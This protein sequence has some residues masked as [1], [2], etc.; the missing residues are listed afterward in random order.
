MRFREFS[1]PI[2]LEY[3]VSM[4]DKELRDEIVS[5]LKTE[6]DR[7]ML[8][9][10]YTA[11]NESGLV[12]RIV[13]ILGKDE[14]AKSKLQIFAG[15]ILQTPGTYAEKDGFLKQFPKGFIDT[16]A[17]T[18]SNAYKSYADWFTGDAFATRVFEQLY[19]FTPQGI[20]PGEYALAIMSPKIQFAG[21]SSTIHGDLVI[22]GVATEVKAKNVAGGRFFDGRKARMDQAAVR[23][24]FLEYD[25]IYNKG[26]SSGMWANDIRPQLEKADIKYLVDKII[27]G[28]FA[29]VKG[30]EVSKLKKALS[31]GDNAQIQ[32]EWGMLSFT[33]Y[34]RMSGFDAMLLLDSPKQSSLYF[35][36]I[37]DVSSLIKS[38]SP[39]VMGPEQQ[40]HPQMSFTGSA[41]GDSLNTGVGPSSPDLKISK[42]KKA[43]PKGKAPKGKLKASGG[44]VEAPTKTGAVR[45]K[46]KS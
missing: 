36:K 40:V 26:M 38:G 8:D 24:A 42:S 17:L 11:L 18:N 7:S 31:T 1:T 25:I 3:D 46:R 33:N 34:K 9:K 2:I 39:Y 14:D 15:I 44:G 41:S 6:D 37:E 4:S 5:M 35:T 13:N 45:S 27:A 30:A 19:T 10:I 23:A 32:H 28:A 29:F 16:K 43:G 21:R 12:D 22:N 20:G